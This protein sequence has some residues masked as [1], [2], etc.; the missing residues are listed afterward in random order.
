MSPFKLIL[1]ETSLVI[2]YVMFVG[3]VSGLTTEP[4]QMEAGPGEEVK[5]SRETQT[6][7]AAL[8]YNQAFYSS[9]TVLLSLVDSNSKVIQRQ[10][11]SHHNVTHL[12]TNQ[13]FFIQLKRVCACA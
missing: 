7:V 11:N 6:K 9:D 10:Y 1:A 4:Q 12:E 2:L 5:M 13:Y 3:W 8:R